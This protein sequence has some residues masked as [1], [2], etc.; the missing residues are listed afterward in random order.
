MAITSVTP[1]SL[2]YKRNIIEICLA[3]RIF[4]FRKV[5]LRLSHLKD[6]RCVIFAHLAT[7]YKYQRFP[8]LTVPN[9]NKN[10][11]CYFP[12]ALSVFL[13]TEKEGAEKRNVLSCIKYTNKNVSEKIKRKRIIF[14]LDNILF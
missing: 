8:N 3:M 12:N 14:V 10:V 7:K 11:I 6:S 1:F 5:R 2:S 4:P 9:M 13:H